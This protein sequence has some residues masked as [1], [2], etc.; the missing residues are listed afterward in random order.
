MWTKVSIAALVISLAGGAFYYMNDEGLKAETSLLTKTTGERDSLELEFNQKDEER[1]DYVAK[2]GVLTSDIKAIEE[3]KVEL[4]DS[5]DDLLASNKTIEA[6]L[7]TKK[8]TLDELKTK[9]KDMENVNAI[10]ARI[11]ALDLENEQ[12]AMEI[13]TEEKKNEALTAQSNQIQANNDALAQ[14]KKDQDARLSPPNLKTSVSRVIDDFGLVVVHG[15]ANDHG[16]VPGSRLAIMRGK[17]KI[18]E[19]TVNAVEGNVSTASVIHSSITAG[20]TIHPGD[21]VVS[22]RPE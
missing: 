15:G 9:S 13:S 14:L 12:L 11:T 18:A 8:T 7:T 5:N 2:N 4:T 6:D 10:A 21:T 16:I 20:E 19:M 17:D 22:V 1:A 3:K